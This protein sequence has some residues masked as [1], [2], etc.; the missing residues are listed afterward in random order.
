MNDRTQDARDHDDSDLIDAAENAPDAVGR[1]GGNLQRDVGTRDELAHLTDPEAQS[2]V[3]KQ[4][5][6][7]HDQAARTNRTPDG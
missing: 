2:Q 4:D 5:A 3:R 7:D 6:I 1:S